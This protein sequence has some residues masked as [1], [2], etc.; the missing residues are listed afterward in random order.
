M[1]NDI[2]DGYRRLR[3]ACRERATRSAQ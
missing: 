3:R 1:E 2:R